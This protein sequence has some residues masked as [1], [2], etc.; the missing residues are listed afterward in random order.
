MLVLSLRKWIR[1]TTFLLLL[2]VGAFL[3]H[4]LLAVLADWTETETS[5]GGGDEGVIAAVFR[6]GHGQESGLTRLDRL[7]LFY[8]LGE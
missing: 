8:R 2:I 6:G 5:R 3:L 1:R 7:K 4:G